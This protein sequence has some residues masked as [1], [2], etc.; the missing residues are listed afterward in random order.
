MC[1]NWYK[2]FFISPNPIVVH[3]IRSCRKQTW[4]RKIKQLQMLLV[5]VG[6]KRRLKVK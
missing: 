5:N 3:D 1:W 4:D 2:P 6:A